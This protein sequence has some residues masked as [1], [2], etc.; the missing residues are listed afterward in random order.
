MKLRLLSLFAASC[1]VAIT[2]CVSGPMHGAVAGCAEGS[3]CVAAATGGS[4]EYSRP[5][6]A[7]GASQTAGR[8]AEVSAAMPYDACPDRGGRAVDTRRQSNRTSHR[9]CR[10]N[11]TRPPF[12]R[13]SSSH[14][15][16]C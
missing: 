13:T 6:D 1:V 7:E 3:D 11:S 15:T 2:G 8:G 14:R 10:E 5:G 9:H 4:G 16:S 12:P